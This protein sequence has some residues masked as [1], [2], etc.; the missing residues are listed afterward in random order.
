MLAFLV[1]A[2]SD[3][4]H[5]QYHSNT[6]EEVRS[7]A[8]KKVGY[9]YDPIYLKHDTG[10]GH[11]E[12]AA[13][14]KAIE[15]AVAP[16]KPSLKILEPIAVSD[17]IL[18]MIHTPEEIELVKA[19]SEAG[20]AI[21]PDTVCSHDSYLAAK[22]AVGAGVVAIDAIKKGQIDRAFCAVRPPGHHA[23]PTTAMGFCLFNTVAITARYAQKQ[24]YRK[25]MIVDFDVH[26]GNGTQ[27][28]FWTDDTVY[29]FGSHQAFIFPGSGSE[30][31][32]GAGKGKGYT[33]NHPMMPDSGDKEVL[34]IYRDELPDSIAFFKP[35]ILL[36]SAGYDLHES[37]P[38]ASLHV[39]TEGIRKMV[40]V[41]LDEAGGIPSV[42]FLEGGYHV[43]A[44]GENVKVT[45]EEMRT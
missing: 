25:V 30:S 33:S 42:F 3:T 37:D 45:I 18:E 19:A 6:T 22:T 23:T 32:I 28:A 15:K 20:R 7:M 9:L 29:Y 12:S 14:L 36:V 8:R 11:P 21:D 26:H 27:D 17:S 39:T 34:E 10:P 44:L 16:I 38:L 13:R 5:H 41:L 24:G 31:E 2:G 1:L 35:D 40:H 4:H 43:D